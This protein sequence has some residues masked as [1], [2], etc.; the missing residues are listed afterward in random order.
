M[1]P[2]RTLIS[3]ALLLP[4]E[5]AVAASPPLFPLSDDVNSDSTIIFDFLFCRFMR[6]K[7]SYISLSAGLRAAS[8]R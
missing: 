5:P 7:I 2:V 6:S 1:R 4:P 8:W 3:L